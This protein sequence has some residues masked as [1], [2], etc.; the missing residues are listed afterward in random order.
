VAR[1]VERQRKR[2]AEDEQVRWRGLEEDVEGTHLS[3]RYTFF[4]SRP[5][6]CL[7]FLCFLSFFLFSCS[8][9]WVCDLLVLFLYFYI[10]LDLDPVVA[11]SRIGH[12]LAQTHPPTY[13]YIY[14]YVKQSLPVF[15]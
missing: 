10:I 7:F 5:L 12:I 13:I 3:F 8:S 14:I 15:L 11:A 6:R 4:C 2:E 9:S 1:K